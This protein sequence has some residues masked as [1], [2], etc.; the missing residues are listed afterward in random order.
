MSELAANLQAPRAAPFRGLGGVLLGGLVLL[1]GLAYWDAFGGLWNYWIEG[2]NWQFLIPVAFVYMLRERRDLYAG[3]TRQPNVPVGTLLLVLACA[4]LV[5]G[6]LS[7]TNG[8]REASMLVTAFALTFLLFGNRYVRKLFWPLAY[9]GLMLSF[10]SELLGMLREPLKL[11]SATVSTEVLRAMGYAVYRQGTFLQLPHITLEVADSCSGLNQLVSSIALGIPLAFT[12]LNRWW[13]RLFIV[14]LSM[15]MGIVMNWVRVVLISIWH[16]ES[17]KTEVHGPHGIYE[18]PFIFLVGVAITI[19]VAM[20]M[21]RRSPPPVHR[22]REMARDEAARP[23]SVASR[24]GPL[25][26]VLPAL[27]G[28]VVLAPTALY[29]TTW[30]PDPVPLA[31]AFA[32]FPMQIAGY[33][34]QRIDQ[35]GVPFRKGVAQEELAVRYVSGTG[36]AAKVFVGYFPF[37]NEQ[38]ELIDFRFNWLHEGAVPVDVPLSAAVPMK[39]S[40][41]K[42]DGRPA[43]AYFH[44][45]VN[46]RQLVDPRKVKLASLVDALAKRRTNGAI[47]VVLFEGGGAEPL[48]PQQREFLEQVFAAAGAL[49]PGT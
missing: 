47:V 19:A 33:S 46:G 25:G 21:S 35:L 45:D 43:T 28:I 34:G 30:K 23:V 6:Q 13:E 20:A 10:P 16:Y 15:V 42:V 31:N 49:L 5:A 22:A 36:A 18:L 39:V 17:A 11:I 32:G 24:A 41:V 9:L 29:L 48:S 3:L 37:Q 8:L 14:A 7:S 4:M 27:A 40:R 12:M 1:L 2:Y 26:T 38:H 44:Y